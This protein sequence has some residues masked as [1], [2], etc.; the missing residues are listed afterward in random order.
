MPKTD[1]NAAIHGVRTPETEA[2]ETM[3]ELL[4]LQAALLWI[5]RYE[6]E[7]VAAAETKFGF[8]LR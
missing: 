4:K 6:P 2:D 3:R 1:W 5:D 8:K 7:I